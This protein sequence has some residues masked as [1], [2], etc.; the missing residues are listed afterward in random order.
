M[1]RCGS[2]TDNG[3]H[4]SFF[5]HMEYEKRGVLHS[6]MP[7]YDQYLDVRHYRVPTW[8]PE[9]AIED[10][11][12]LH[13]RLLQSI[14]TL[15]LADDR[16]SLAKGL[17]SIIQV[18]WWRRFPIDGAELWPMLEAHGVLTSLRADAV[19]LFDFGLFTLLYAQGRAPNRRRRMTP[20]SQGRYLTKRQR[21]LNTR[22]FGRP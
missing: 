14:R 8:L 2:V 16:S 4:R 1:C 9:L 5:V 6:V 17:H 19:E 15:F 10:N 18:C 3:F 20:M 13:E 22:L 21:E 12:A 7:G 11:A